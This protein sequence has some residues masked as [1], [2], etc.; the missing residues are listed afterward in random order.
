MNFSRTVQL[1]KRNER[2]RTRRANES[3]DETFERRNSERRRR[4]Q[5]HME[6]IAVE[7]QNRSVDVEEHDIRMYTFMLTNPKV[8]FF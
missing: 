5:L 6:S 2:R 8:I 7:M 3:L 1:L 4:T